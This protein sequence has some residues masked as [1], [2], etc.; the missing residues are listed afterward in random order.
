MERPRFRRYFLH[1][2]FWPLWLGLGG[3]WLV[4]QLPYGAL[5][6]L[7][8][9]LGLGMYRV[10]S[11]RRR[12]A[13]R[14]LELCFPQM[15]PVERKRLLKENFASTGIAFF[16]MAM[17]WW[18]PKARLAKLAHIEGL[19]HLQAAQRDGEGAILMALHF[20]TLEIGAALLGQRH[21]IDGMYREHRNALF[22]FVQRQGRERHNLDSLAVERE[23]VRGMIKLLR[24]G[25]AIWYAPD[26]D[27]GAKQSIFV[28]L[29]GI[30]AATVTATTH[31]ARLGKARVIPFTQRRLEDGSGYR[32][33]LHPPLEGFPGE[34]EAADALRINQWV[35]QAVT[36][37]P[38]QYLWAHRRFKSRPAGA[39]KLYDKRR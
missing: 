24:K 33:V 11:E 26:Q 4:V 8:R 3:L 30:E 36:E 9:W 2:R 17:S 37:C 21:T 14:N 38:E 13:A 23:D 12:V 22:D 7:G 6:R 39:P 19:E 15:P 16:E 18:W 29:F 5:L 10:A 20:T 32:L 35:E 25:R 27:Y 28:P 1:P 31:F 34:S